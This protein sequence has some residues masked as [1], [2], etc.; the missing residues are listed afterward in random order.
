MTAIGDP[1]TSSGQNPSNNGPSDQS[2]GKK[3][4]KSASSDADF[5]LELDLG[6]TNEFFASK[7]ERDILRDIE[8]YDINKIPPSIEHAELHTE[9][10]KFGQPVQNLEMEKVKFCP[11]CCNIETVPFDAFVSTE[12]LDCFGPVIPLFFQFSK[13]LILLTF[14]LC[15]FAAVGQYYIIKA[16]CSPGKRQE[17]CRNNIRMV[18]IYAHRDLSDRFAYYQV[19]SFLLAGI[20]AVTFLCFGMFHKRAIKLKEKIDKGMITASDYT[21]MMYDIAEIVKINIGKFEGNLE[22]LKKD[23]ADIDAGIS[24]I[25]KYLVSQET[26]LDKDLKEGLNKKLETLEK[27]KK[28]LQSKLEDYQ[29]R[30]C[31]NPSF[32]ENSIAFV[33]MKYM[34]DAEKVY[35]LETV[36]RKILWILSKIFWCFVPKKLHY[37]RQAP[38]PDDIKWKFIGFSPFQRGKTY[39]V[40][41]VVTLLAIVASFGVQMGVRI[42]QATLMKRYNEN[43]PSKTTFYLVKVLGVLGSVVVSLANFLLVALSMRMSRYEKHLSYSM[44]TLSHTRK[45]IVLQFVNTAGVVI[46]LTYLPQD[47]GGV[48]NFAETV[49][50]NQITNLCLNPLLHA[51]DPSHLVRMLKQRTVKKKMTAD[52]NYSEMTQK[53]LNE[54]FEPADITI[55]LRYCSVIRTFFVSCFFF[56]ALPSGMFVCLVFLVVQF[57]VDKLMV[58]R[59]YKRPTRYHHSLNFSLAQFAEKSVLLMI[60]GHVAFKHNLAESFGYPGF[61]IDLVCLIVA[62]LLIFFPI[63]EYAHAK[64]NEEREYL[65]NRNESLIS[66]MRSARNT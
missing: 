26:T 16:N 32:K 37:V 34:I 45:L 24:S 27:K 6:A 57:W 38:E 7:L 8:N 48:K 35:E 62:C 53:E 50:L 52:S 51:F 14:I 22:R 4:E 61:P 5:A 39:F 18:V 42:L 33:S 49:F 36:I 31:E 30:I 23:I 3:G 66:K 20:T 29:K 64:V 47:L 63:F 13:F 46:A 60:L 1:G 41:Y 56:H 11:C 17:Y 28:D 19:A 59:R 25:S 2:K 12:D 40:S 9:C 15:L 54:L 58:L 10:C 65:N 55:Y 43:S 21:V 44:F